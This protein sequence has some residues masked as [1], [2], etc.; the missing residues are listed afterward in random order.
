M[1]LESIEFTEGPGVQQ[2][3]DALARGELA[4]L[5]PP[6]DSIGPAAELG[7][8]VELIQLLDLILDSQV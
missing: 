7:A 4:L 5:V 2:N 1:S 6:L 8:G 3:V